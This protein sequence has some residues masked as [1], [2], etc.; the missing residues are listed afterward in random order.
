MRAS[1]NNADMTKSARVKAAYIAR[2]VVEEM[3]IGVYGISGAY[4]HSDEM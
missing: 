3:K 2:L 1:A 4:V